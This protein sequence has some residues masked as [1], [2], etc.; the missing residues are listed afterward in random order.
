MK[1]FNSIK[2][3]ILVLLITICIYESYYI[4][5]PTRIPTSY[6][7]K[8]I[9]THKSISSKRMIIILRWVKDG[10]K[11]YYYI[12]NTKYEFTG[13]AKE[14]LVQVLKQ[15]PKESLLLY[16]TK[17]TCVYMLVD[18]IW[19]CCKDM[20]FIARYFNPYIDSTINNTGCFSWQYH[21][22]NANMVDYYWEGK[23]I[24]ENRQGFLKLIDC[25]SSTNKKHLFINSNFRWHGMPSVS[26]YC[27]GKH[28]DELEKDHPA[29]RFYDVLDKNEI[30]VYYLFPHIFK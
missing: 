3:I 10:N 27:L 9:N 21:N 7:T 16:S 23:F 18:K 17:Q 1:Q 25:L 15:Y 20:N 14:E 30:K 11:D 12:N 2:I 26:M 24:G 22:N 6:A 8:I 19:E 28:F 29:R 13:N 4:F 5:T